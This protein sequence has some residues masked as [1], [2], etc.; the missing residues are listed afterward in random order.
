MRYATKKLIA[1]VSYLADVTVP[2]L[3]SARY[4]GARVCTDSLMSEAHS[5]QRH[6]RLLEHP[7]AHAE[8]VWIT[9]IPWPR[10]YDNASQ[11]AGQLDAAGIVVVDNYRLHTENLRH[12]LE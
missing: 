4:V 3:W 2:C 9:R 6:L 8:V 7:R 11:L 5:Q 12:E 10:G 1:R